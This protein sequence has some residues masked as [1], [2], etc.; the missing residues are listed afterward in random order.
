MHGN[1]Y[2]WTSAIFYFGY[3]A[4]SFPSSYVIVRLP[5]G[6]YLSVSVYVPPRAQCEYL[7]SE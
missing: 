1:Q 7:L 6:K 5:I 2:S 3:L 4:W